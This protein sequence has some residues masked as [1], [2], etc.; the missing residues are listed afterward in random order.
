MQALGHMH[1]VW[2]SYDPVTSTFMSNCADGKILK[3]HLIKTSLVNKAIVKAQGA[4]PMMRDEDD[5]SRKWKSLKL[6]HPLHQK[7]LLSLL[8]I[9]PAI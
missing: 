3:M 4:R 1:C 2:S 7:H 8:Y 5:E 6:N 9:M